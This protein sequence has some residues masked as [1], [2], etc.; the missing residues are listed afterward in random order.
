MP[1]L[2]TMSMSHQN[3]KLTNKSISKISHL[4][5]NGKKKGGERGWWVQGGWIPWQSSSSNSG[6][7][8]PG[9]CIPPLAKQLGFYQPCSMAK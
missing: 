4:Q 9:A 2:Y 3:L 8:L 5:M 1:M 6:L 7:S